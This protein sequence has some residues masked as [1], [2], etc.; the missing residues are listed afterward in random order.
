MAAVLPPAAHAE[1]PPP[2]AHSAPVSVD[3]LEWLVDTLQNDQDRAKLVADLRALIAA[4]RGAT[5]EKPAAVTFLGQLSQQIDALTGEILAG[6]AVIVD[7]P[8]LLGWA[9]E[10]ILDPAARARWP[11]PRRLAGHGKPNRSSIVINVSHSDRTMA[12]ARPHRATASS[13]RGLQSRTRRAL[14]QSTS[15]RGR[16]VRSG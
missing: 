1:S 16:A 4:Q 6:V 12:T 3:D 5:P 9:R 7:A 8:R 13:A 15:G 10:Q 2:A 14:C 11:D